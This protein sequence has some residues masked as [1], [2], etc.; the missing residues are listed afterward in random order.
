MVTGTVFS[1]DYRGHDD[2]N[3]KNMSDSDESEDFNPSEWKV[4]HSWQC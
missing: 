4:K 2:N 1:S 3:E